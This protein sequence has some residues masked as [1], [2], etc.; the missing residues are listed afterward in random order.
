MS[1]SNIEIETGHNG[2]GEHCDDQLM[3]YGGGAALGG[4]PNTV[5]EK[6][7]PI[8]STFLILYIHSFL[9]T[10]ACLG[11]VEGC[12]LNPVP[13]QTAPLIFKTMKIMGSRSLLFGLTI[14]D[15]IYIVLL[16]NMNYCR[17]CWSYICCWCMLV[18]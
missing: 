11:A 12:F 4:K 8:R 3:R 13:G 2:A 9:T 16:Y 14:Y 7:F 17:I 5:I 6:V 10:G 15:M 18:S 1:D